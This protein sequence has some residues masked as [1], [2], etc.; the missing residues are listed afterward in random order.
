MPGGKIYLP[1]PVSNA[2]TSSFLRC[3]ACY[4]QM[5][6]SGQTYLCSQMH[7]FD[8]AR[9]GYINLLLAHQKKTKQ[10]GDSKEMILARAHF[11]N[12]GYYQ[13]LS[14]Q[15]NEATL[16][17]V[18]A[19]EHTGLGI[20]LDVGCGEGYYLARLREACVSHPFLQHLS[21]HFMG[22]DISKAAI[23][24]AT[25]RSKQITWVVASVASLPLMDASCSV[26][27]SIFA[28]M[29]V[30]E[31]MRVL[32]PQGT[33]ILVTPG[34]SHLYE[35]RELLYEEVREHS[36]DDFLQHAS[37]SFEVV[38][39]ERVTFDL[40]VANAPDIMSLYRMTPFFWKS[41]VQAHT[42]V[43]QLETLKMH[44]DVY[45]RTLQKRI[46]DC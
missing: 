24:Q 23:Q 46:Q 20:I 22:L 4:E 25:R 15:I 38:R 42:R 9:Q 7:T 13:P 34:P 33:L 44:A 39:T 12:Q 32:K 28:P 30:P 40:H 19:G 3:P 29:N 16:A 8:I 2:A 35:L 1:D 45:V 11:L 26:I 43:E 10:P 41:S 17:C 21:S 18:N 36:Q 37:P 14:E 31:F 27:V 6:N 5:T